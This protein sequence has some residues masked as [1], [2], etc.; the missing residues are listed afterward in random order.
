MSG[1]DAPSAEAESISLAAQGGAAAFQPGHSAQPIPAVPADAGIPRSRPAPQAS[2]PSAV[3]AAGQSAVSQIDAQLIE[4]SN[5]QRQTE[6]GR[7]QLELLTTQDQIQEISRRQSGTVSG[8]SE[9]PLLVGIMS[10]RQGVIAEF[11][12]GGAVLQVAQ[13][14]MV[15]PE[16]R[17]E[18]IGTNNVE[19]KRSGRSERHVLMFGGSSRTP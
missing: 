13:G 18:K 3:P 16:W 5:L 19:I 15:S 12:S 7:A 2:A 6:R 11:L 8:L 1:R 14:E 9:V 17:L 4:L 10:T